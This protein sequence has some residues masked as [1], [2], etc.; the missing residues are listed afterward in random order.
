M[1]AYHRTR[2]ENQTPGPNLR[3]GN[4]KSKA[5]SR[6]C[7]GV[8][9]VAQSCMGECGGILRFPLDSLASSGIAHSL[10]FL[11][12]W[13]YDRCTGSPTLAVPE[14]DCPLL[15]LDITCFHMPWLAQLSQPST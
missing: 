13:E 2:T 8:A 14:S 11:S 6:D 15:H 1:Q 9:R 3:P 4:R 5:E 12:P 10:A 7:F